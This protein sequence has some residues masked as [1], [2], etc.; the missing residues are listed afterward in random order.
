[1]LNCCD[2]VKRLIEQTTSDLIGNLEEP[3]RRSP[4]MT[5]Q[6]GCVSCALL[7]SLNPGCSRDLLDSPLRYV[8]CVTME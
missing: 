2:Y 3:A 1:M 6:R 5:S 4:V 7:L 8:T